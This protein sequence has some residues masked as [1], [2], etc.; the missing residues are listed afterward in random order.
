MGNALTVGRRRVLFASAEAYPFVKAGGLADVSGALPKALAV[1]GLDV[2]LV[3]PGYRGL[4]GRP[5]MTLDVPF[6]PVAEQVTV[7]RLATQAGVEVLTLGSPTWF[8]RDDPYG[9]S[10]DDI[11][12]FVL[13]S[14]AVAALAARQEW[15]PD[16][17]HCNDWHC[18]LV[19]QEIRQGAC[20]RALAGTAVVFTIHNGAYRGRVGAAT[21][22]LIGLPPSGTL[23]ERGITFSDRVNTV[24]RRYLQELSSPS[25]GGSLHRP[26]LDRGDAAS[27]ILNGVDYEEFTPEF[28]PWI[29]TQY[30]GTFVAGKCANKAVLQRSSGLEQAP[31]RPLLGMVARL[32]SQK[33]VGLLCSALE[34]LVDRGAQVVVMGEGEARYRRDLQAAVRRLPGSVAY[35]RTAREDLA[36]QVYAGSD[37]FLAPSVFEPCGLTPL[38]ALRYGTI[39]V[40]RR[41]GGLADTVRDYAEDPATGLGFVFVHRRV[42]SLL[43]AVDAALAVYRRPLE[44]QRLQKRAMAADFSWRE[45]A[46]EYVRLYADAVRARRVAATTRVRT[47]RGAAA[48][49]ALAG[50]LRGAR[51]PLRRRQ[52]PAP[53]PL[54]L[55]HH[56]NQFL[57]TDGYADREGLTALVGGYR[58]LLGLHEKYRIPVNLHMSGTLVEAAAWAHPEFLADIR[59]LREV[60]L[61]SLVG[62]TYAENVLTVFDREFNRRQ[63]RELF[64]LYQRHLGCDPDELDICWVPERVWDTD[65]LSGVLTDPSLPN[66]GYR[67]VLLDDRLLYP[68]EGGGN[69]GRGYGD[70]G[71]GDSGYGD[72]GYGGRGYEGSDRAD[73]DGGDPAGPPPAD[74][75]RPYLISGGDGLQV[76]PMSTRLRYWIPPEDRSHWRSLSRVAELATAPGDD[77][78]LV[79]ADDME[80]SAGVGAWHPSALERYEHFLRWLCAQPGLAPVALPAWLRARRRAPAT[81]EVQRGTFVE[82]AQDWHAGET[83][84][85]WAGDDAWRPYQDHLSEA[86]R[87]VALAEGAGAEPRL[88]ALAWKHLLASAYET[89]WHDTYH[90]DRPPAAWAKAAA[91]HARAATVLV[92]AARWFAQP[93]RLLQAALVDVD[94]DGV[95]ELVLRNEH[96]FAV[97]TPTFGGR[98]VYLATRG[99]DGGALVIGN[100]TDDWNCQEDLNRYMDVPA[101]HPG[102][103]VDV[104]HPHDRYEVAVHHEGGTVRVEMVDTSPESPLRGLRKTLLLEGGGSALLVGYDLP[105]AVDG[106]T[107]ETGLSPDYYQLVRHGAEGVRRRGGRY[108]RGASTGRVAVWIARAGD[109][110]T[111]W[112]AAGGSGPAHAVIVGLRA[113][114]P[115]FHLLVGVGETDD[116]TA[117][118]AV[119]AARDRLAHLAVPTSTVPTP[120]VPSPAVPTSTRALR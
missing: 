103:L 58:R 52:R 46:R 63:L 73:F 44:W 32:V 33:G 18:G 53:L 2:R 114:A 69:G 55:V 117:P 60:G 84:R 86:R 41:T 14:K 4:R 37:L 105:A 17:V 116:R 120:A 61:L 92:A 6:G 25:S 15:L 70:R 45:P 94:D 113:G 42:A 91:S 101:N 118:A 11:L 48:S 9:Y 13:F 40:V 29:D 104:G 34:P 20:R 74:A 96:L 82:L 85:G 106:V 21:D 83:Y 80:K 64:W 5:L 31:D 49:E 93:E 35:H 36:R 99:R 43:A 112:T 95:E 7:E 98:L 10:D 24:S 65:R 109:E 110:D 87:A 97:F 81:R 76:V 78:I 59:R 27:G 62:G 111:G 66:G 54:A 79:H 77:T 68:T 89:A 100:P 1:L 72:S 102:G 23:L 51:V 16:V 108:W 26:L 57:V 115:S 12:P 107:V 22:R 88:T 56:A 67:Y 75:L 38:I 50:T 8:D 28:D 90:P 71:Y 119:R 30:N 47:A 3:I 19:A 39:P